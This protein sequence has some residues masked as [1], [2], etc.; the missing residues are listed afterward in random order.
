M[1]NRYR[2]VRLETIGQLLGVVD[3]ENSLANKE[4]D[5]LVQWIESIIGVEPETCPC[6][7][8]RLKE[9]K[10]TTKL[11]TKTPRVIATNSIRGSPK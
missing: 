7:G 6:C 9:T 1:A 4:P 11:A 8:D 5:W 2:R 3:T 10:L